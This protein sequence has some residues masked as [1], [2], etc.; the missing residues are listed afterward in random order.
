MSEQ[1]Q[2]WVTAKDLRDPSFWSCCGVP[3]LIMLLIVVG[4]MFKFARWAFF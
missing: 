3:S 2:S 4:V 1:K